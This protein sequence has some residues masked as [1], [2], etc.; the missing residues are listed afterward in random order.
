MSY[1]KK[2]I[3]VGFG[4][5]LGSEPFI[6]YTGDLKILTCFVVK[7]GNKKEQLV[8]EFHT[9]KFSKTTQID[10]HSSGEQWQNLNKSNIYKSIP[11]RKSVNILGND[12]ITD[13]S[14]KAVDLKNLKTTKTKTIK[15][16]TI[17]KLTGGSY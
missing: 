16:L 14:G 2:L 4:S 17:N 5:C 8:P 1:N 7:K 6:N 11:K 9:D 13:A 12:T 3:G 10:W 15:K